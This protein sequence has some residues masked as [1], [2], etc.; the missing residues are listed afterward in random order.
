[1]SFKIKKVM[2]E[3]INK[4]PTSYL[5]YINRKYLHD[6]SGCRICL[7]GRANKMR[8]DNLGSSLKIISCFL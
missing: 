7:E 8:K 4:C 6:C 3:S 2:K 1:M 5:D